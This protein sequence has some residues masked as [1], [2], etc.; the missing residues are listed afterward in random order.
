MDNQNATIISG[1]PGVGKSTFAR[2]HPDTVLDLDSPKFSK[3]E[4]FPENYIKAIIAADRLNHYEYI[5]V[6]TH[7]QVREAMTANNISYINV[8]P[9]I[10]LKELYLEQFKLRGDSPEFID[11]IDKN[12]ETFIEQL[13][14]DGVAIVEL[15][16]Y[17]DEYL[18]EAIKSDRVDE[19]IIAYTMSPFTKEEWEFLLYDMGM[20]T[21]NG[22]E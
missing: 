5:L 15:D 19:A 17:G 2:R 12:F 16:L 4:N 11:F 21:D 3:S 13:V 14:S 7:E 8:F 20:N 10:E 22:R 1:F 6:S 18:E 9:S